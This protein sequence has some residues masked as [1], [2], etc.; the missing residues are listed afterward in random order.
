MA[1]SGCALIAPRPAPPLP[2]DVVAARAALEDRWRSFADM[3]SLADIEIHRGDR[4]QRLAGVLLLRAPDALRFEA[5]SPF[6]P[7][8]LLVGASGDG[9]TV[10]EVL[11]NRAYLLPSSPDSAKRWLGVALGPEDLVALLSGHVRPLPDATEG[12]LLPVDSVGPSLSLKGEGGA[13]RIWLAPDGGR[14][15]QAE[16][17]GGKHPLR[18]VFTSGGA[19]GPPS[20]VDLAT[21]DG[22]LSVSVRYRDPQVD[23]GLDPELL[24]LSVPERVRIQDFR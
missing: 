11:A 4:V 23:V 3:R 20:R 17:T 2:A 8:I 14:P 12:A 13:Q 9:V 21:L 7:P 15:L 1:L 5:L 24:R 19:N 18:V 22:R 10:W 6:G 16:W